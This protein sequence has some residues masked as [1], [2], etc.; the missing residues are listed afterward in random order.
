MRERETL[1][2]SMT[3]KGTSYSYTCGAR[4]TSSHAVHIKCELIHK[5]MYSAGV[6]R[7]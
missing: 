7:P 2:S 5:I 4:T 3:H 1:S 6:P